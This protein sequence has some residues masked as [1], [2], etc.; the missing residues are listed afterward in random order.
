M[1]FGKEQS[2]YCYEGTDILRNRFDMRSHKGLE[3]V[4]HEFTDLRMA[5]LFSLDTVTLPGFGLEALTDIHRHLFC[6]VYGWAGRPRTEDIAKG[7]MAFM[8]FEDI[9]EAARSTR[10]FL[11]GRD[12]LRGLDVGQFIKE[13]ANIHGFL[14]AVHLFREGNGRTNRTFL[15]LLARNAGY[16][17][18]Y[19]DYPKD[20]QVQADRLSMAR[21]DDTAL[22]L[23]YANMVDSYDGPQKIVVRD[24]A[25]PLRRQVGEEPAMAPMTRKAF[26][27]EVRRSR[28]ERGADTRR[29]A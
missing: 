25:A 10:T 3:I 5:Q 21:D 19:S 7:G 13:L 11:E 20:L 28:A 17:I 16:D 1:I 4:E 22:V 8:H 29:K 26:D 18:H 15:K 6:D 12:N 27:A 23:M 2:S 24:D 9:E 14:N